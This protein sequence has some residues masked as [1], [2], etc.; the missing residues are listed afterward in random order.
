[1]PNY[2]RLNSCNSFCS[3]L[4]YRSRLQVS[5]ILWLKCKKSNRY[6]SIKIEK[7]DSLLFFVINRW[8]HI[9][10]SV[11]DRTREERGEAPL[12]GKGGNVVFTRTKLLCDY[13]LL[14]WASYTSNISLIC[15]V[16][17]DPDSTKRRRIPKSRYDSIS[18]F[19]SECNTT[20]PEYN[21]IPLVHDESIYNILRNAGIQEHMAKH[22]AHLFIRYGI[23]WIE[24]ITWV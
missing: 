6:F 9:A 15:I 3:R 19:L 2:A 5:Q 11:D 7:I 4:S 17:D 23:Y 1:M 21:D 12:S 16:V 8:D 14:L 24:L 10:S 18:S 22:V 13:F 20:C